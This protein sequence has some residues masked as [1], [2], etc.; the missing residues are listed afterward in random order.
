MNMTPAAI[1]K[2]CIIFVL[3]ICSVMF[4]ASCHVGSLS[5]LRPN[6]GMFSAANPFRNPDHIQFT[7]AAAGIAL[8]NHRIVP[9]QALTGKKKFD[10][11]EC[12][13]MALSNNLDLQVARLDEI[14][15]KSIE[16]SNRTKVLPHLAYSGELS[17]R[18]NTLYSY[19]DPMGFEGQ[20][21][22]AGGGTGVN[23]WATSHERGT[24]RFSY[25][26]RWSPTD[27]ALAFYV[28]RSSMNDSLKAHYQR[29]RVAQ[30]L[31]GVVDAAYFHLLTL[32]QCL[33]MAEEL[34]IICARVAKNTERLLE[35]RLKQIEDYHRAKQRLIKAR[36]ILDA[37]RNEAER[38]RNNLASAMGLAPGFGKDC[39]ISVVGRLEAPDFRADVCQLEM[40]AVL[41]RP[42]AY[43]AGLN[44]MNSVNDL[45]R[46]V[47][48]YFPKLTGFWRQ[49]HDKDKY[50]WNKDWR[51]VGMYM[52][53][54]VLDWIVNRDEAAAADAMVVKTNREVG[55]VALGISSQV[56]L[57]ALKYFE[58]MD[59]LKSAEESL[60]SSNKVLQI[61]QQRLERD[62]AGELAV[63]EA[64]ANVLQEKIERL[65]TIG[66]ANASLADLHTALGTNYREG[67]PHS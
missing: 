17:E 14:I 41:N 36:S 2:R 7:R 10:L 5:S 1:L 61:S 27:A 32:E 50:I 28:T 33:P 29:V 59:K 44:H 19:S 53:F 11:A 56:R 63:D 22:Q 42:E 15:K 6:L 30:K 66:D 31:I 54:D 48:K 51:D 4:M 40:E 3:A 64:R 46:A 67:L 13:A 65:R 25:E 55:A 23:N 57:A 16:T 49:T 18:D 60:I 20:A 8:E 47:I 34:V 21:P 9:A 26:C 24:W 37:I 45:R 43:Q 35:N 12:R 38:E 58:A 39:G 62:S 52:Y